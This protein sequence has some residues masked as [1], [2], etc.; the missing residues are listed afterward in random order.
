MRAN[1]NGAA[2]TRWDV[3]AV[4]IAAG[5]IAALQIGKVPPSLPVLRAELGISFVTAGW[6]ASLFHL[7]GATLAILAS[8][9]SDRMGPVPVVVVSMAAVG[10]GAA[11]GGFADGAGFL[12]A[13]RFLEGLGFVGAVVSAPTIIVAATEKRHR[14]LALGIW[15][16]YFPAG[17]AAA[18]IAAPHIIAASGWRGLWWANAA[19]CLGF[20]LVLYAVLRRG[21]WP[22]APKGGPGRSWAEI[23]ATFAL[24]GPLLFAGAFF[25]YAAQFYAVMTWLPTFLI[26]RLGYDLAAAALTG[27]AVVIANVSGNLS[28]ALL[29]H[30]QWRRWVVI[31]ISFASYAGFAWFVFA[32]GAA[33]PWRVPAAFAL[34]YFAGFLPP[35][36]LAGAP[37]HARHQREVATCNG[38]V[39]HGSNLGNVLGAPAFAFAVSSFGGWGNGHLPMIAA[40][41]LGFALVFAVRAVDRER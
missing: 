14:S 28:G 34:A 24:P 10:A 5:V 11:L 40:S 35:A 29:L 2:A 18:M 33:D 25:L 26:E 13:A 20:A 30:R 21:R 7:C 17:A 8:L 19:I 23:G 4:A 36:C 16:A 15:A 1:G 31:A 32:S 39:V 38:I 12:L 9:T 3:V 37:A 6:V 41:L 22:E 27:A